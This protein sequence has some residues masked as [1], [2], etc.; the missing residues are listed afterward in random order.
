MIKR[1]ECAYVPVSNVK[2]SADWYEQVL[3]M[4]LRSPVESGRGAIM[5]ME[6]GGWLFL[7]PSPDMTP[8][9]FS[10]TG[11]EEDGQ[12]FEMF[13]LCFETDK[14]HTLHASL[15]EA[16]VWVEQELRNEGSCGL[17]LNFKDPDGN[18]YQV[19]QQPSDQAE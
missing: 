12:A 1:I 7:L 6:E 16:G 9:T 17:Q 4:R 2:K 19:W 8:L 14:I 13:P 18:K 11:W 10:T 5:V 3:G 15:K